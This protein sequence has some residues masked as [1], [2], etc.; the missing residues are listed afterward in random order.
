MKF[1]LA[2]SR[3][4]LGRGHRAQLALLLDAAPRRPGTTPAIA[5]GCSLKVLDIPRGKRSKLRVPDPLAAPTVD[6]L[7]RTRPTGAA[8]AGSAACAGSAAN[9]GGVTLG[10]CR[11]AGVAADGPRCARRWAGVANASARRTTRRASAHRASAHRAACAASGS[12]AARRTAT[13]SL[14]PSGSTEREHEAGSE[15]ECRH[16]HVCSP[17]RVS[18]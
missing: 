5:A 8:R 4:R 12:C 14:R 2:N 13:G 16:T 18:R 1:S 7:S 17:D 15:S 6:R 9:L 3:T 10:V 11:I